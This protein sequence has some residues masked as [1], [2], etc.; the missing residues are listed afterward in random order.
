[1][2]GKRLRILSLEDRFTQKFMTGGLTPMARLSA[3]L[4]MLMMMG[5]L[6]TFRPAYPARQ[7]AD[8]ELFLQQAPFRLR[9]AGKHLPGRLTHIGAIQIQPDAANQP[10]HFGFAETGIGAGR[11]TL[12]AVITRLNTFR[13]RIHIHVRETGMRL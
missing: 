12:G 11:T 3:H 8:L 4:A 7:Q 13:E 5:M 1:V 10:M 2:V 6:L 9:P